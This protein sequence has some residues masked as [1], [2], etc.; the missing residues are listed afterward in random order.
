VEPG[1]LRAD[2]TL[3]HLGEHVGIALPS[4][5]RVDHLRPDLVNTVDVTLE[6]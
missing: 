4:D 5:E 2:P 3:G 6:S 1:N